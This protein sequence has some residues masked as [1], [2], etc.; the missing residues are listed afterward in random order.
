MSYRP[1]IPRRL[2]L[3]SLL[4]AAAASVPAAENATA[5]AAPSTKPNI[6]LI[7]VD[8]LGSGDLG[9]FGS[10]LHRT[11]NLDRMAQQGTKFTSF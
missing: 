10:K 8:N 4:I 3:A 5:A 1:Y 9:C 6:V 7:V 11:P 2:A